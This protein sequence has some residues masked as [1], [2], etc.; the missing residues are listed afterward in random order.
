MWRWIWVCEVYWQKQ[1]FQRTDPLFSNE[2]VLSFQQNESRVIYNPFLIRII[3]PWTTF[4][5]LFCMCVFVCGAYVCWEGA[6]MKKSEEVSGPF[7]FS[8]VAQGIKLRSSDL[9]SKEVYPSICPEG[10]LRAI[11]SRIQTFESLKKISYIFSKTSMYI[12]EKLK[13]CLSWSD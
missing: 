2:V 1:L 8:T 10:L 9:C 4:K 7:S 5:K 11:K 6:C 3:L 12:I 13:Y